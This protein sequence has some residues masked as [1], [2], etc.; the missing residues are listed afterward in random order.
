MNRYK[1]WRDEQGKRIPTDQREICLNCKGWS[2]TYRGHFDAGAMA[3]CEKISCVPHPHPSVEGVMVYVEGHD[4]GKGPMA[5][6]TR[7]NFSCQLFEKKVKK[8]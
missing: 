3:M 5:V 4:P 8:K 1:E 6:S 2:E 7:W